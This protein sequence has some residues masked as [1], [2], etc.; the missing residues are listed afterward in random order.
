MRYRAVVSTHHSFK[1]LIAW[2]RA[3]KLVQSSYR[4]A[5]RLPHAERFGLS[6]Q[7][8]RCAVSVPSNI[9]EGHARSGTRD[10]ARLL[11]IAMGSLR[12]LE[13]QILIVQQL[14]MVDD[15]SCAQALEDIDAV[16]RVLAGLLARVSH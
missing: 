6:L 15:E 12:E 9:A 7:I 1:D 4:L 13:T 5:S 8:R 10:F 11:G 2:Q 14:R 16:G 3:M